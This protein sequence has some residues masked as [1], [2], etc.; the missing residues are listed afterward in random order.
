VRGWVKHKTLAKILSPWRLEN[1]T[2]PRQAERRRTSLSHGRGFSG[3]RRFRVPGVRSVRVR[4]V[5]WF[6]VARLKSP[7]DMNSVVTGLSLPGAGTIWTGMFAVLRRRWPSRRRK[8]KRLAARGRRHR[9]RGPIDIRQHSVDSRVL[10]VAGD[11]DGYVR[12]ETEMTGLAAALA[13][14]GKFGA[15]P[16]NFWCASPCSPMDCRR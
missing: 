7:P 13:L 6:G 3:C 5:R 12:K 1:G 14:A 2:L 8:M 9:D 11:E 16:L 10:A 4:R 15:R